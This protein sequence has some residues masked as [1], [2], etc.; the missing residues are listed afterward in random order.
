MR[1]GRRAIEEAT[2]RLTRAMDRA[3]ADLGRAH[4]SRRGSA[5]V[6][7]G[8]EGH[9]TNGHKDDGGVHK[10]GRTAE[11]DYDR[12]V[13]QHMYVM[14]ACLSCNRPLTIAEMRLSQAAWVPVAS[15]GPVLML[16]KSTYS[17]PSHQALYSSDCVSIN[18]NLFVFSYSN[19]CSSIPNRKQFA[20]TLLANC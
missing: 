7:P 17:H 18:E 9:P 20:S 12:Y 3:D 11:Q 14:L 2:Q 13:C 10:L 6:S 4:R 15:Y 16:A 5:G 1:R 19:C 8:Y